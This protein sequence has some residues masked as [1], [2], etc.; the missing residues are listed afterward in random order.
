MPTPILARKR[1]RFDDMTADA[2]QDF[3][4]FLRRA[5]PRWVDGSRSLSQLAARRDHQR[6]QA[7]GRRRGYRLVSAPA[8]PVPSGLVVRRRRR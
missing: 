5:A 3:A 8:Q 1:T 4:T 6:E 7:R 2:I